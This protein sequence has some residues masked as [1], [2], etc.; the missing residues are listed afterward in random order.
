[1]VIL[2]AEGGV[3]DGGVDVFCSS[4]CNMISW[5]YYEYNGIFINQSLS[6][7]ESL[8]GQPGTLRALVALEAFI[9]CITLSLADTTT[10]EVSILGR[11][12][13]FDQP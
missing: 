11:P 1:M 8:P 9:V 7:T 12:R 13:H 6:L 2:L 3:P 4:V 10:I 5:Y